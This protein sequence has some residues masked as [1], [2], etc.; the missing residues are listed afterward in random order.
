MSRL[1]K[2]RIGK[3]FVVD[4]YGKANLSLSG[5][6][7]IFSVLIGLRKPI[8]KKEIVRRVIASKG[9]ESAWV[10]YT[11]SRFYKAADSKPAY[12]KRR[13]LK[14]IPYALKPVDVAEPI[15][16][17]NDTEG[18]RLSTAFDIAIRNATG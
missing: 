2:K 4:A 12:L 14:L 6:Q 7:S 16:V 1:T 15:L 17:G 13:V 11:A 5:T 8:S 10:K 3:G 18:Y 9:G